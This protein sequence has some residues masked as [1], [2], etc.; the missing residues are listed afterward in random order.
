MYTSRPPGKNTTP[1]GC[2]PPTSIRS[3]TLWIYDACVYIMYVCVCHTVCVH[4]CMHACSKPTIFPSALT[5]C[6]CMHVCMYACKFTH[7]CEC[8]F[9]CMYISVCMYACIYVCT[10]QTS[11]HSLWYSEPLCIYVYMYIRMSVR[12]HTHTMHVFIC[13]YERLPVILWTSAASE[14]L[15][16]NFV[17]M[18]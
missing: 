2:F 10:F 12:V 17:F 9:V 13:T 18:I 11:S 15:R 3:N 1:S 7:V 14:L 8:V 5:L 6:I 16:E 4:V